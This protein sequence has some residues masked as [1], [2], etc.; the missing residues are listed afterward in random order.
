[1]TDTLAPLLEALRACTAWLRAAKKRGAV[2]GGVAA[3]IHGQPRVTQ[4]ID[5][6]ALV[7]DDEWAAFL[8]VGVK[9]GIEPRRRDA[10]A[11]ATTTRVLLLRHKPSGVELDVSLGAIAFEHRM[12][13][14]A[15]TRRVR[16][17][18]F[19]VATAEDVVVM[20]ALALRP[21]DVA[22]IE[23]ILAAVPELAIER[24]RRDLRA[25]S[26]SLEG[27][28]YLSELDRIIAHH[29]RSAPRVTRKPKR[30]L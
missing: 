23:G 3:S 25:L 16:G 10:L 7:P 26:E 4:D 8:V 27:P 19:R 9:F 15:L 21:R 2:I 11:F 12:V 1:M 22:D 5:L 6:V 17:V 14:R 13:E 29:R 20:K 28:D 30:K 18:S 24:V